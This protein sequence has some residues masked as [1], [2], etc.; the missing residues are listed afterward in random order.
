MKDDNKNIFPVYLSIDEVYD[1]NNLMKLID[2]MSFYF[3]ESIDFP[4]SDIKSQLKM[5]IDY[6][7]ENLD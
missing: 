3:N 1:L 7:R 2:D 4:F 6:I 5:H